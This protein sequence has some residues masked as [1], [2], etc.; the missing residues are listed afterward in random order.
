MSFKEK[1]IG[2]RFLRICPQLNNPSTFADVTV[3][4]SETPSDQRLLARRERADRERSEVRARILRSARNTLRKGSMF[5]LTIMSLASDV[6]VSRQ[7]IYR[8]FPTV[9]DVFRALSDEVIAD[10][11]SNLPDL[12]FSD[13]GYISAFVDRAVKT[14]CADSKVVRVLVLTSAIG[15]ATGDWVQID[16]EQVLRSALTEMPVVHRPISPD[17]K[18]AARVLITYF[19]GA[20]YGWAAGFLTDNEFEQEVRKA[21]LLVIA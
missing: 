13:P 4:A 9:Q 3:V 14:F 21:G 8:H 16:P 11:Y 7:T 10:I 15:R 6:G 20:L 18:V 1:D 2:K 12:P 5:D 17:P 19:R